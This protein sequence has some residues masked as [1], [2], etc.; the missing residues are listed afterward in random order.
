MPRPATGF[1]VIGPAR[2]ASIP[3]RD[4]KFESHPLQR[5]VTSELACHV[6]IGLPPDADRLRADGSVTVIGVDN[7]MWGSGYPHSESTFPQSRKI[8]AEILDGLD[9]AMDA[10][11]VGGK[12]PTCGISSALASNRSL[13]Y[14]WANVGLRNRAR[15]W[16]ACTRSERRFCRAEISTTIKPFTSCCCR[17]CASRS[18]R[19]HRPDR[20]SRCDPYGAAT[21]GSLLASTQPKKLQAIV[22]SPGVNI[23]RSPS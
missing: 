5:R 11:V 18:A 21:A 17:G 9:S 10:R 23:T 4:H 16:T 12:K 14:A 22:I 20:P 1:S 2:A 8:L 19:R 13:S 6:G 15:C 7:M 3:E